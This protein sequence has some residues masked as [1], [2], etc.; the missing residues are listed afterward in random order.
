MKSPNGLRKICRIANRRKC[1]S[2]ARFAPR[3]VIARQIYDSPRNN[4]NSTQFALRSVIATI[5]P[6]FVVNYTNPPRICIKSAQNPHSKIGATMNPNATEIA[7]IIVPGIIKLWLK[8]NFP[9]R[10]VPVS[11]IAIAA[12]VVG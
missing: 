10:V 2:N 9:T 8:T 7:T 6:R 11:S 12:S 3:I 1:E 5:A 4:D